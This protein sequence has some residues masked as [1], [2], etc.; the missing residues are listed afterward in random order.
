MGKKLII[1]II[2]FILLLLVVGLALF[3][4]KCP[5][6]TICE[7]G[8]YF[9]CENK[10]FGSHW[11]LKENSNECNVD[12]WKK[13]CEEGETRCVDGGYYVCEDLMGEGAEWIKEAGSNKCEDISVI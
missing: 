2:V 11:I 7:N 4:N 3:V 12:W 9:T 1:G 5:E 10:F 8:D 13:E 6:T